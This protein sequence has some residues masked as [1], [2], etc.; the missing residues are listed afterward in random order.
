MKLG[1]LLLSFLWIGI[2]HSAYAG[3]P[4][5]AMLTQTK[6]DVQV[7][8]DGK[9]W[10]AVDRNKFLFAGYQIKTGADGSGKL[11][12]QTT[13][14]TR[15]IGAGSLVEVT[16]DDAKAISGML[17][18]AAQD[19]GGLVSGL[20]QRFA[21][22]QRYTTVRR[23]VE[24]KKVLKLDT[25]KE[26][27]LSASYPDLVWSGIG[28]EYAYRLTI[29]DKS[30]DVAATSGDVVRFTVPALT[31][32]THEYRVEVLKGSETAYAPKKA[33][34]ITWLSKDEETGIVDALAKIEASSPG[35][36]LYKAMFLDE[37]GMSVSAMDL[38]TKYF[39]ANADDT[40]M[41]PMLI[42]AYHDLELE[43][44]K[45]AGALKLQDM[46]KQEEKG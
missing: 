21:K 36:S 20:G 1:V 38:Y 22:A 40:D 25:V 24:K 17:S 37:K 15:E 32:G 12:N 39:D 2:I 46:L 5:V 45:K 27:T 4:P 28:E 3:G 33:G 31:P 23:S 44:M 42:K 11:V 19:S 13:N 10:K 34:K 30:Y 43:K 8:K 6:G 9:K 16:A 18:E 35:D 7:S 41:Y 14:L 26:I 29:G